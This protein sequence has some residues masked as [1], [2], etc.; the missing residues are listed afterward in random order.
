[1]Y[2]RHDL[3]WFILVKLCVCVLGAVSAFYK[4]NANTNYF[5]WCMTCLQINKLHFIASSIAGRTNETQ[6]MRI[7]HQFNYLTKWKRFYLSISD[8]HFITWKKANFFTVTFKTSNIKNKLKKEDPLSR[9]TDLFLGWSLK[10]T[11]RNLTHVSLN[12]DTLN[13]IRNSGPFI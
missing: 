12:Y 1:M 13:S 6:V 7:F 9:G 8:L 4:C 5:H 2:V 11:D 3:I 10:T